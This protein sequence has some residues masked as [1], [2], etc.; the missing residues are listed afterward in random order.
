MKPSTSLMMGMAPYPACQFL[1]ASSLCLGLTDGG[2]HEILLPTGTS[3]ACP[4]A[5]VKPYYA[6]DPRPSLV[7]T[8]AAH[9]RALDVG[10]TAVSNGL[11]RSRPPTVS[12][13]G[14]IN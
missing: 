10:A 4:A 7:T 12:Q 6:R 3:D 9:P 2:I 14:P 5:D 11:L 8:S 13:R 1:G